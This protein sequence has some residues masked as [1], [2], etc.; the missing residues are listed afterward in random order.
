MKSI[1]INT[2]RRVFFKKGIVRLGSGTRK[3]GKIPSQSGA[4]NGAEIDNLP[5]YLVLCVRILMT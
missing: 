2:W 5:R 1:I 4:A 3:S